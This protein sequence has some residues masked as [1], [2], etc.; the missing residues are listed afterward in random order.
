[1]IPSPVLFELQNFSQYK[2]MLICR[3]FP[4]KQIYCKSSGCL[5]YKGYIITP[6]HQT[7]YLT[8][9]KILLDVLF[10]EGEIGKS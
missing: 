4:A 3:A 6:P 5:N 8:A 10:N 2:E 7:F 1:M 9:K